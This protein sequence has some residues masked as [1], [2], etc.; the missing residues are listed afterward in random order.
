MASSLPAQPPALETEAQQECKMK[1]GQAEALAWR[2]LGQLPTEE[3]DCD[4]WTFI[5]IA[6]KIKKKEKEMATHTS[7]LAGKPH[8]QRGAAGAS[9][10]G[11]RRGGHNLAAKQQQRGD[12]GEQTGG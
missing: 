8:G 3:S 9:P 12:G 11:H 1:T 2:C 7:I 6:N 5:L 4:H 10:R